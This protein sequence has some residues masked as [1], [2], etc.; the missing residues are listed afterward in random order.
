MPSLQATDTLKLIYDLV[1]QQHAPLQRFAAGDDLL[2]EING[3]EVHATL[4]QNKEALF[5]DLSFLDKLAPEDYVTLSLIQNNDAA[6]LLWEYTFVTLDID[7]DSDNNNGY[8]LP[9]MSQGEERVDSS[10]ND[11]THPGK[12]MH[13]HNQG[14]NGNAVPLF[15][16]F[17]PTSVGG[18]VEIVVHIDNVVADAMANAMVQF[19]YSASDPDPKNAQVYGDDKTGYQYIPADGALRI[20]TKP[21][22]ENRTPKSVMAGGDWV[23]SNVSIPLSRLPRVVDHNLILYVES[24]AL[25]H[26]PGDQ[27]I[28]VKLNQL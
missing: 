22:I 20:W 10:L 16:Q 23:P 27:L 21:A 18:F 15:M 14:D 11:R 5:S 28:K 3:Q 8:N 1:G 26:L 4:G 9:D 2:F 13:I 24:V 6:N 25:S 12:V 19:Y 7:I 17:S